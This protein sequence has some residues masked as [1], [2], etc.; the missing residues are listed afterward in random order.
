MRKGSKAVIDD[1]PQLSSNLKELRSTLKS[2]GILA[3]D[4]EVLNLTQDYAFNSPSNAAS[5][6]LG[7]SANGR[8]EW[9]DS[10]ERTLK[11]IQDATI[12]E[13]M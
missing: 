13:S 9:K 2:N 4:G 12:E 10:N 11:E 8:I 1:V 5:A 6:L 3:P 7:R